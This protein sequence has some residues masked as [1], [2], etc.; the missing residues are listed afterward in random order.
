MA[1]LKDKE[2]LCADIPTGSGLVYNCLAGHIGSGQMSLPVIFSLEFYLLEYIIYKDLFLKCYMQ[3]QNQL[4]RRE[5]LIS[6]NIRVSKGL[7]RACR[8]DI[9]TYRCR[10]LVSDDKDVRLAQLL[11]CLENAI[12]NGKVK[13][14]K[15]INI[16]TI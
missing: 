3:C 6:G 14:A 5:K 7:T 15:S 4:W 9:R 10:R 8:E 13:N 16:Y 2:K 1:C 11:L 12:H